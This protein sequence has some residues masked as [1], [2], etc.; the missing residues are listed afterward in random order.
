MA[1]SEQIKSLIGYYFDEDKEKFI[2]SALQ[3]A[4][5][6]ARL[7]HQDFANDI[8]H[9]VE[10]AKLPPPSF[11]AFDKDLSE[12]VF[13]VET[14]YRLQDLIVQK[15]V[16]DRIN[17]II[18]EYINQN[19]LKKHGLSNRRKL[20]LI[21]PPGT[22]KT[23]SASIIANELH[24]PFYTILMDKVFT[25]F[26]GETSI[27]LRKVFEIIGKKQ[28]V[29]LFDEFDAIG[30]ERSHENEL[31]E[32]RRVLNTFLQMIEQD[33]SNSIVIA[34]SNSPKILDKALYRRFDDFIEYHL[35]EEKDALHLISNNL[36]TFLD[37]SMDLK[38]I[39]KDCQG[40][41]QAEIVQACRDTVKE[42]IL[43]D[44]E[45]VDSDMLK[46]RIL[47]KKISTLYKQLI[48]TQT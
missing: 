27:K 31:G 9:M 43:D 4:A 29:Y 45:K 28:G 17:R 46:A 30:V 12:Y 42:T 3:I 11:I 32:I 21:G 22:G 13:Q 7:G 24:L 25:K 40:L 26:M 37:Q 36:G 41:S 8:R 15:Q 18:R 16:K 47:E 2:T 5:H 20:F 44:H 23:M 38:N 33:N 14:S 48:S 39:A 19:K 1:T 35:P 6:E 10:K 34:A